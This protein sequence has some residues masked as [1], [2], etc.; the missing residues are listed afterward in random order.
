MAQASD[1][2]PL[3]KQGVPHP[4]RAF[5]EG[6]EPQLSA[7]SNQSIP[8]FDNGGVHLDRDNANDPGYPGVIKNVVQLSVNFSIRSRGPNFKL[9]GEIISAFSPRDRSSRHI[10]EWT[11]RDSNPPPSFDRELYYLLLHGPC[12]SFASRRERCNVP[13]FFDGWKLGNV[14]SVP[15]FSQG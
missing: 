13:Q 10:G 1:L 9:L 12:G 7:P 5:R 3:P 4:S 11:R 14:P 8:V 2:Q 15:G 6:W